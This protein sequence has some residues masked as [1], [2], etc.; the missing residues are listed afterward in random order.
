MVRIAPSIVNESPSRIYLSAPSAV[1]RLRLKTKDRYLGVFTL[2]V[3]TLDPRADWVR[4]DGYGSGQGEAGRAPACKGYVRLG[5]DYLVVGGD[6]VEIAWYRLCSECAV[7]G[8]GEVV[9][10][11]AEQAQ[12]YAGGR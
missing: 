2:G 11:V 9:E 8:L 12:T 5:D 6:A 4:C 10:E 1:R 3:L 7:G